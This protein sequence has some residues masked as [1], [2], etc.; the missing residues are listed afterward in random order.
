MLHRRTC[1]VDLADPSDLGCRHSSIRLGRSVRSFEVREFTERFEYRREYLISR[2][3]PDMEHLVVTRVTQSKDVLP[4]PLPDLLGERLRSRLPDDDLGGQSA[5]H[6][7]TQCVWHAGRTGSTGKDC[8]RSSADR[9]ER[10]ADLLLERCRDRTDR[11]QFCIEG[12]V[13]L[14]KELLDQRSNEQGGADSARNCPDNSHAT[15]L[16][17]HLETRGERDSARR[18]RPGQPLHK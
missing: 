11:S 14:D 13:T 10:A 1:V 12:A 5:H 18:C 7:Q 17:D 4:Q 15:S 6:G 2:A 3:V 9:G 8:R 16:G